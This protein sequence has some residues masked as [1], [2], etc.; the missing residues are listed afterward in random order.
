MAM[1][2]AQTGC[3]D[4]LCA[5]KLCKRKE[6]VMNTMT[7]NLMPSRLPAGFFAILALAASLLAPNARA[8]VEVARRWAAT[9]P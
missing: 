4:L 8:D 6:T 9:A 2:H 7:C 5:M 1:A 3:A